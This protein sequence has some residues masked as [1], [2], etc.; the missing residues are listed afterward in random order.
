VDVPGLGAEALGQL[1]CRR[2]LVV[3]VVDVSGVR[4]VRDSSGIRGVEAGDD[5][6]P[7]DGDDV[8]GQVRDVLPCGLGAHVHPQ[9][10]GRHLDRDAAHG[11]GQRV[12]VH[13]PGELRQERD[14]PGGGAG[15]GQVPLQHPALGGHEGETR[16]EGAAGA[17]ADVRVGHAD[18]DR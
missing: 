13:G 7:G 10:Q 16:G 2:A 9:P 12:G 5:V 6:E 14:A 11:I 3:E 4:G 1:P 18:Q 15:V 17:G 8:V